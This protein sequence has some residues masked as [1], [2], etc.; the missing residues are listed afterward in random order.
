[1]RRLSSSSF[2]TSDKA[3][4]SCGRGQRPSVGFFFRSELCPISFN[5][6]YGTYAFRKADANKLESEQV[7]ERPSTAYFL[8]R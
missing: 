6:Y 1:M 8:Q 5:L 7:R 4:F 3:K 2:D